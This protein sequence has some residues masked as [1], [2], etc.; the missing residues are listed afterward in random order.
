MSSIKNEQKLENIKYLLSI[1][2][3]LHKKAKIKTAQDGITL[4]SILLKAIEKY[5][6]V[7]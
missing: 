3:D 7:I 6:N 1:P 2:S 5:T 4:K